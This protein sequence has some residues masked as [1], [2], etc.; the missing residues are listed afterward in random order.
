[1][2]G[3]G[4]EPIEEIT[5]NEIETEFEQGHAV[6]NYGYGKISTYNLVN[7]IAI[8]GVFESSDI[9]G[10]F[11]TH[12]SPTDYLEQQRKLVEIKGILDK[13]T[14]IITKIVIFRIDEPA[15]GVYKNGLT[16][17]QIIGLMYEFCQ[18]LFLL[19]PVIII[20]SCDMST[21]RCGKASISPTGLNADLTPIRIPSRS[22]ETRELSAKPPEPR[23]LS[24]KPTETFIVEVL[25]NEDNEKIYKCPICKLISGTA[26]PRY[27][28]D[29]SFF[30]HRSGC[31]NINKIPIEN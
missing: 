2:I 4:G 1:V 10:T 23:K 29:T 3:G 15:I 25:H 27:P 20:Y 31:P 12:E 11:L 28:T 17:I 16:T 18:K 5:E 7:C 30:I 13:K 22:S 19:T 9:H 21:M 26:A 6:I 14:A 8:G 24:A